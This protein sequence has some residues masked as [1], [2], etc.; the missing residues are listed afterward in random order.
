M[1]P[2]NKHV[3]IMFVFIA[4]AGGNDEQPKPSVTEP[5]AKIGP[6]KIYWQLWFKGVLH[7]L[8]PQKAP[9]LACFV[10]DLKIINTFLKNNIYI[11]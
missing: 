4:D 8:S 2:M 3:S 6:G 9:K 11:L 1:L 10:F 7:L 5:D